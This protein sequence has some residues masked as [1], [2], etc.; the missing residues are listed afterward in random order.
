MKSGHGRR[1]GLKKG[2]VRKKTD[3]LV[4]QIDELPAMSVNP[5]VELVMQFGVAVPLVLPYQHVW[6]WQ[7]RFFSIF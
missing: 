5:A 3:K 4:Q 7:Q 2:M 6:Q 1:A